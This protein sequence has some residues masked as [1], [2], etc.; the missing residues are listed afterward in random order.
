MSAMQ[1]R[2]FDLDV[3]TFVSELV[4][5]IAGAR[6]GEAR[7][8]EESLDGFHGE[9]TLVVNAGVGSKLG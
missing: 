8:R 7:G 2:G 1:R 6:H 5:V 4:G 9:E 3:P